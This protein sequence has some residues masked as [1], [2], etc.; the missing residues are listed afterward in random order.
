MY[1]LGLI[2]EM[3]NVFQE[4]RKSNKTIPIEA[5]LVLAISAKLQRLCAVTDITAATMDIDILE[6]LGYEMKVTGEDLMSE[7]EIRSFVNKYK[8]EELIDYYNQIAQKIIKKMKYDDEKNIHQH[9]S[10]DLEVRFENSNYEG[11]EITKGKERRIY[12]RL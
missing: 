7:G 11:A 1:K 5:I 4:R 3:V 9:D 10:T 12:K 8:A 6:K 2:E